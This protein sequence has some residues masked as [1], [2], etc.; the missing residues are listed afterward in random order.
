MGMNSIRRTRTLT[1]RT[2]PLVHRD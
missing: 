1:S 2:L